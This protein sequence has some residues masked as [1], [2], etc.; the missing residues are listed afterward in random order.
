MRLLILVCF[1]TMIVF[2]Y[3]AHAQESG[4][5]PPPMFG[6][7]PTPTPVTPK[8]P[9]KKQQPKPAVERPKP[10]APVAST[11]KLPIPKPKPEVKQQRPV[12]AQPVKKATPE[13]VEIPVPKEEKVVAAPV[14]PKAIELKGVVR[15]PKTMP[16]VQKE[17]VQAIVTFEEDPTKPVDLIDRAQNTPQP[18]QKQPKPIAPRQE[19][20]IKPLTE[21]RQITLLF[22]KKQRAVTPLHKKLLRPAL[23]KPENLERIY[24]EAYARDGN[25]ASLQ[26]AF[27]IREYL[28]ENGIQPQVI[29]LRAYGNRTQT[30]PLDRVDIAIHVDKAL[31]ITQ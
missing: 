17:S 27:H 18:V 4:Y 6:G 24:I 29:N 21:D 22:I 2:S 28:I 19:K 16:A 13:P 25:A 30:I 1:L 9:V 5:A 23:L 12:L 10:V 15:G 7:A 14:Q 20:E 26:R 8:E 11:K 31:L 3:P